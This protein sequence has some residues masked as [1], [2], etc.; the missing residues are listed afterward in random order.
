MRK[1]PLRL[2]AVLVAVMPLACGGAPPPEPASPKPTQAAS[3]T[4]V[5]AAPVQVAQA[6]QVDLSPVPE[7]E[8]VVGL[9]RW[10]SPDATLRSIAK[11][12]GLPE[13]LVTSQSETVVTEIL[14]ETMHGVVNEEQLAPVIATDAPVDAVAALDPS[15]NKRDG[16]GAIAI[17]LRSLERAKEAAAASGPVVEVAPGVFR[18]GEKRH[19]Q[20]ACVIAASAGPVPARLVCGPRDRDVMALTPYLTRTLS[21]VPAGPTDVHAELRVAPIDQ[22]FG[23][24]ARQVLAGAPMYAQSELSI[25]EPK[26]DR[27]LME[28]ASALADET[29]DLL[30]DID[31]IGMDFSLSPTAGLT[32]S[33]SLSLR[34]TKSWIAQGIAERPTKTG[35][36]PMFWRLPKD[37]EMAVFAGGSDPARYSNILR[38][39]RTL[40][41]GVLTKENIGTPA[42]RRALA[43]LIAMPLQKT[44]SSVQAS[45]HTDDTKSKAKEAA[46]QKIDAMLD[47]YVGW[48][49]TGVDEAPAATV[50]YLKDFVAVYNRRSLLQP[51]R[52][53]LGDDA[54]FL[55]TVKT[56]PPPAQLGAGALDVEIKVSNIPA[57]EFDKAFGGSGAKGKTLSVAVH[58][59]V[60]GDGGTTWIAIGTNRDSLVK[61]LLSVKNGA[62]ESATLATRS[63]LEPLKSTAP[64]TGGFFTIAAVTAS[65]KSS[66]EMMPAGGSEAREMAD[67]LS[68]MPNGG[69]TPMILTGT[70]SSGSPVVSQTSFNVPR[71]TMEDIAAMVMSF[72]QSH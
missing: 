62:P 19:S 60:M 42:D 38:T 3:P 4:Q 24:L 68:K 51:L 12:A 46:Q 54:K 29:S 56:V 32:M 63:G 34:R 50:K 25:G 66:M 41:D 57:D 27:T 22:R 53:E 18:I 23:A 40:L 65:L 5:A 9:A 28:A 72:V 2:G 49:L 52:D 21:T 26:F 35:A 16:F 48:H 17:G 37:S 44:T 47:S 36:P 7:P 10:R 45:G 13:T 11:T 1:T 58:M 39:L 43:E 30:G 71:G 67:A 15:P 8:G 55:P 61:R 69:L 64:W 31:K 70:V 33:G 14:R 59:L 6:P 20:G